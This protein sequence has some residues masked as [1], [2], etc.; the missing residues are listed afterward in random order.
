MNWTSRRLR[1]GTLV[2]QADRHTDADAYH[3]VRPRSDGWERE[4]IFAASSETEDA[5]E[6]H[7]SLVHNPGFPL[8]SDIDY[9]T[10]R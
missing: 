7:R 5:N 10:R 2:I 8:L 3:I 1:Q 4:L 9:H 6:L